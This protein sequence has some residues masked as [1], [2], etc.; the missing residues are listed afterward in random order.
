MSFIRRNL[1][2]QVPELRDLEKTGLFSKSETHAIMRRRTDFEHRCASRG[3]QPKDF[4]KYAAFEINLEKLRRKRKSRLSED[5]ARRSLSDSTGFRNA[6]FIFDRAV[7]KFPAESE[8]WLQYLKFAKE[9][10]AV[11]TVYRVYGK[12]LLM[13]PRN[14]DAWLLAAKYEF[15]VNFNAA[16]TRELYQR[17]LRLN[18]ES[19]ELW[20][21]YATFE[22]AYVAKLLAR[23]KVLGLMTEK[24]QEKDEQDRAEELQRRKEGDGDDDDI[25]E[26]H[27][28][29]L[30]ADDL[31]LK[32]LPDKDMSVLGNPDTN[33][34]LKG[35]VALTIF[36]LAVP[37]LTKHAEKDRKT[38]VAFAFAD[39][40]L[41]VIDKFE[42]LDRDHLYGHVVRYLQHHF[43]LDVR[44][45]LTDLVLPLRTVNVKDSNLAEL[46]QLSVNKFNAYR[47]KMEADAKA[48]FVGLFVRYIEDRFIASAESKAAVLLRAIVARCREGK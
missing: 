19:S 39:D 18:P 34:V 26:N 36:D 22:L 16:G 33:P 4:L 30:I 5:E 15:E 11:K 44:T 6:I 31:V 45:A 21:S 3:T 40:F 9:K 29:I 2:R 14:I 41:A 1:E 42:S 32:S 12:M 7:S 38:T 8:I 35:D 13:Q 17:G 28:V 37:E 10:D 20:L 24:S 43:A 48:E 27:D 23:R 46:L 25:S 47:A